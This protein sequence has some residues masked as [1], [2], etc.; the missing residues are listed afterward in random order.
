MLEYKQLFSNKGGHCLGCLAR[1]WG[2]LTNEFGFFAILGTQTITSTAVSAFSNVI[3][4][5]SSHF[6]LFHLKSFRF[7]IFFSVVE[8][9]S[10]F[11]VWSNLLSVRIY[12]SHNRWKQ[13]THRLKICRASNLLSMMNNCH[14]MKSFTILRASTILGTSSLNPNI[15]S[16]RSIQRVSQQ[17]C[18]WWPK[19]FL[20]TRFHFS[21]ALKKNSLC[22]LFNTIYSIPE[23]LIF[24]GLGNW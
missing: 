4:I 21:D 11:S 24:I 2:N 6:S 13:I 10:K 19:A 14:T 9:Q 16:W 5:T 22:Y 15:L 17:P 12:Y 20:R 23:M 8:N 18:T 7:W 3:W 1:Q